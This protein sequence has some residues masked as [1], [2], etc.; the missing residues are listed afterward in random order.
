M[1]DIVCVVNFMHK[2]VRN[3]LTV[4]SASTSSLAAFAALIKQ[5]KNVNTVTM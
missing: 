2:F 4:S 1:I 5:L 3:Y